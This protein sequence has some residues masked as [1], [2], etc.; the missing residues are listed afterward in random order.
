MTNYFLMKFNP[1]IRNTNKEIMTIEEYLNR[2]DIN[3]TATIV[4]GMGTMYL[5]DFI[6]Q[7]AESNH[8]QQT[9]SRLT[10]EMIE[11]KYPIGHELNYSYEN[12]LKQ[13]G[14]KWARDKQL[15]VT[16]RNHRCPA[17]M[18]IEGFACCCVEY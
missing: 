6:K 8:Q 12:E 14:A 2:N 15:I 3:L 5:K 10:D 9:K 16:E 1:S 13:N 18:K 4:T 17:C 7:F 11:D